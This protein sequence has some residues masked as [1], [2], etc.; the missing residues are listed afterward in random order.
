M[1]KVIDKKLFVGR[2]FPSSMMNAQKSFMESNQQLEN[3]EVF[4]KF[5][6]DHDLEN[7]RTALIVSAP[8]SFMYWYGV[9]L[10]DKP[11]DVPT[12]LMKFELPKAEIDEEE[13]ENQNLVYFNLPL[14]STVPNFVKRVVANGVKVYQNLGDSDTPYIVW[15]LNLDTKKLTQDFYVKVSE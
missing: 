2:P 3:D 7:K 5:L 12:G 8:E 1:K 13:E 9:L 6:A 14:V 15:D 10:D 4:Q 11:I